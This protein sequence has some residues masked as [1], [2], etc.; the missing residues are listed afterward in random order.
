MIPQYCRQAHAIIIIFSINRKESFDAAADRHYK[1][2]Q[3]SGEKPVLL[4]GNKCDLADERQVQANEG[5]ELAQKWNTVYYETS[6]KKRI[7]VDEMF[8]AAIRLALGNA[9]GTAA[10]NAASNSN[11]MKRCLVM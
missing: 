11:G 9:Q 4:V 3:G 1:D 5:N 6:A 8:T 10:A 7:N 2:S